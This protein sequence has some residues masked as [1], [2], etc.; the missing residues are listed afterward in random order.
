MLSTVDEAFNE[1]FE[2][3]YSEEGWKEEKKND[4]GDIVVS[5]KSKKGKNRKKRV[6]VTALRKLNGVAPLLFR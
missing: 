3:L 5:K 1:A 4:E 2:I 6:F